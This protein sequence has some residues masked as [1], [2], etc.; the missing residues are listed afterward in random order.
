MSAMSVGTCDNVDNLLD[1]VYGTIMSPVVFPKPLESTEAGPALPPS[2]QR[3]YLWTDSFGILTYVSQAIKAKQLN[4]MTKYDMNMS[5]AKMLIEAVYDCLGQPTNMDKYPM[6]PY[7]ESEPTCSPK[8]TI[9]FNGLRIGKL[10]SCKGSTDIGMKYDGMYWH[11][12]DK[13]IFAVCRF[14]VEAKDAEELSR[15]VRLVK[16]IFPKF[17][18]LDKGI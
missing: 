2:N 10:H 5:S 15:V 11:Y 7:I 8:K 6:T 4:D 1:I 17:F 16:S 18:V 12:T 3:R 13:F 9:K 14:A